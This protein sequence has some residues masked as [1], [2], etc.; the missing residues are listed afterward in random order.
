MVDKALTLRYECFG[1]QGHDMPSPELKSKGRCPRCAGAASITG[2]GA[3]SQE[4]Q[5]FE[6]QPG[7]EPWAP[8]SCGR[9]HVGQAL[10]MALRW[11]QAEVIPAAPLTEN[12]GE[13]AGE[14]GSPTG[15]KN[16]HGELSAQRSWPEPAAGV[17]GVT[18]SRL[19]E[20]AFSGFLLSLAFTL[21]WHQA[22]HAAL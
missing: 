22:A 3:L 4:I 18:G 1:S 9:P 15:S 7:A 10:Q 13:L 6:P 12:K 14:A 19:Q 8:C 21:P 17:G 2:L 5:R 11:R 20:T 16:L